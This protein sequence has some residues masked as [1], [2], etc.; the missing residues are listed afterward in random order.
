MCSV[1]I[2]DQYL[3]VQCIARRTALSRPRGFT[4]N[5]RSCSESH[6]YHSL[7]RRASII[8][9]RQNPAFS[10]LLLVISTNLQN[11]TT[12]DMSSD[13]DQPIVSYNASCHCGKLKYTVKNR[14]LSHG[15]AV[16]SCNCSICTRNAYLLVYPKHEDVIF[17][18]GYDDLISFVFGKNKG[19]HKFCSTCG[20]N[21]LA[22]FPG[23]DCYC[24]N[25]GPLLI[26]NRSHNVNYLIN[27]CPDS[28]V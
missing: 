11:Q 21:A 2:S 9:A 25:V 12:S 7:K 26:Q 1:P 18:S 20:C 14:S 13:A 6:L 16:M 23:D 19:L 4:Q 22:D 24:I 10:R 15:H 28:N 27:C 17:Q 5:T 3:R 8:L